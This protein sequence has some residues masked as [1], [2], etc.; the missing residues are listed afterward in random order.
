MPIIASLNAWAEVWAGFMWNRVLDSVIVLVIVSVIWLLV[1]RR[2]SPHLGYFLFLLVLLKLILPIEFVTPTQLASF[3]PYHLAQRTSDWTAGYELYRTPF[4]LPNSPFLEFEAANKRSG[5]AASSQS[6]QASTINTSKINSSENQFTTRLTYSAIFMCSWFGVVILLLFLFLRAQ[7]N[8]YKVV[9]NARIIDPSCLPIDVERLKNIAKVKQQVSL[10]MSSSVQSPVVWGIFRPTLL[11]PKDFFNNFSH[12]QINWILLHELAHIRRGDGFMCLFQKIIQIA[13][14][15][16]PAVWFANRVVNQQREFICDDFALSACDTPRDECGEGFLTL[17]KR[18]NTWP[19]FMTSPLG[20]LNT[21]KQIRRRMM[22][23]LDTNRTLHISLSVASAVFLFVV[24]FIVMPTAPAR[25][26]D[27]ANTEQVLRDAV[28]NGNLDLVKSLISEGANINEKDEEGRT[29]LHTAAY[30]GRRNA[31]KFLLE[32]GADVDAKDESGQTP[33]HLAVDYSSVPHVPKLLLDREAEVNAR[34]KV[35]NTPLHLAVN[36]WN[37]DESLLELL[38]HKGADIHAR[39]NDGQT[40]LHVAAHWA[41]E[42]KRNE[43]AVNFLLN[44]GAKIKAKDKNGYTPLLTAARNGRDKIVQLLL[45]K[46]SDIDERSDDGLEAIHLAARYGHKNVV[47]LLLDEGSGINVQDSQGMTPL[48]YAIK[49]KHNDLI[50]FLVQQEIDVKIKDSQGLTSL[51]YAARYGQKDLI[52]PLIEPLV[53]QGADVNAKS[54]HNVT[55][56]HCAILHC[57]KEIVE[58]LMAKGAEISTIQLASYIGNL[59]KVKNFIDK[60]IGVNTQDGLGLTPLHAAAAGGQ[61]KTVEFLINQGASVNAKQVEQGFIPLHYAAGE[62]FKEVAELLIKK[63]AHADEKNNWGVAP[64]HSAVNRG[65]KELTMLLLSYGADVNIKSDY[66]YT[67]LHY[68]ALKGHKE[69]AELLIDNGADVSAEVSREISSFTPF[70]YAVVKGYKDVAEL[71]I[72][73]G[74]DVELQPNL[75]HFAC[76]NGYIDMVEF[77]IQKGA[78]PSGLWHEHQS[79]AHYAIWN[80]YPDLLQLLLDH[81][82]DPNAKDRWDWSLL[83]Y[84]AWDGETDMTQML[85]D[86]GANSNVKENEF[87][88]TPLHAAV[89]NGHK[90][91]AEMLIKHGADVNAKEFGGQT[92]LDRAK[93]KGYD[94][95]IELLKEH[96]AK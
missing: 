48:F 79:P 36:G 64:L 81:G 57:Q 76:W 88:G 96:G 24:A 52:E 30:F 19:L 71:L 9:R 4:Q 3:S 28:A 17:V 42:E 78:N 89:Q 73:K 13:F 83:H 38:F 2:A 66:D 60:G 49:Y 90:D 91:V 75:L 84:T 70:Y 85:L 50:E 39:N 5:N 40:P 8:T 80:D 41:K 26:Q 56:A 82:A 44:N 65:K 10:A 34:D 21:N 43:I 77:L 27:E 54:N 62:G 51:H 68:A 67:P 33:L 58:F 23:I 45:A 29:L 47:E 6:P 22:R 61:S 53:N 95:I 55:P 72:D 12:N 11:V 15:F 25:T 69:I 14:F 16:N 93:E 7:R 92:P 20:M 31:T 74:Y 35:N 18:T 32:K 1:H 86:H 94:E 59:Q 37:E 63:G 46:G 87:G